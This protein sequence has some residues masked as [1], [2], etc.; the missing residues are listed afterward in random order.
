MMFKG[1]EVTLHIMVD[2]FVT[3][4]ADLHPSFLK[5]PEA[6]VAFVYAS[7]LHIGQN[8]GRSA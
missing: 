3:F 6:V 2:T 1:T 5:P 8:L 7:S 4:I